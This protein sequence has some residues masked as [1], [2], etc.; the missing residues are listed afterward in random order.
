ME[1]SQSRS[2]KQP[3]EAIVLRG[4]DLVIDERRRDFAND[5]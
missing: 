3:W 4:M 2:P 5:C 1:A